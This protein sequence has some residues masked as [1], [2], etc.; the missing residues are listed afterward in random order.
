VGKKTMASFE[1]S[2]TLPCPP[3]RAFEFLSRPANVPLISPPELGLCLVSAP[4]VVSRGSRIEFQVRAFGMVRTLVHEI[5]ECVSPTRICETQVEGVFAHWVHD[6]IITPAGQGGA[7]VLDRIE[8]EPPKG[9]LGLMLT[10]SR[11]LEHLEE[12]YDHRHL[13]MQALLGRRA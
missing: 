13:K 6:H 7:M 10:R 12:A 1:S 11:I 4:E 5:T 2:V 3:E 8:F 9:V